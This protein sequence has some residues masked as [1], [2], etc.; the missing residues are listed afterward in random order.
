MSYTVSVR[1]VDLT[2]MPAITA[3]YQHYVRTHTAT[4]EIDP[5]D[6]VEMTA[7]LQRI[8]DAGSP[9]LVAE[10]AGQLLGYGYAGPYRPRAA[11][12][13]TVENSIYLHPDH[14]G[15]GIGGRLLAGL[16]E[17]CTQ[18]GYRE[19]VAVIGDSQNHS[20]IR[21]HAKAGFT[22]VGTLRNVGYKFDR[23]LDTVLMQRSLNTDEG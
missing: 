11:Y 18:A 9:Y 7:R 23:W 15:R 4:F 10:E 17:R 21:L 14:V 8:R 5:P 19:M 6:L 22:H 12:R 2:D 16:I 1:P 13:H 20:S 3:I